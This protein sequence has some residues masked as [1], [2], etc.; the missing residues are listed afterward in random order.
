MCATILIPD[1]HDSEINLL[2]RYGFSTTL[3]AV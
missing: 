2:T 1:R 3:L